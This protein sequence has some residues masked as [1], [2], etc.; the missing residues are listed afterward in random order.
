MRAIPIAAA[1]LALAGCTGH[2]GADAALHVVSSIVFWS[3]L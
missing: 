3:L 1:L 2:T